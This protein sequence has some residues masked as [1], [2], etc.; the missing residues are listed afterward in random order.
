MS[1]STLDRRP[2]PTGHV[3]T[4]YPAAPVRPRVRRT[5]AGPASRQSTNVATRRPVT[6]GA[7][8]HRIAGTRCA[9]PVSAQRIRT[10]RAG[11]VAVLVGIALALTVWIIGVLGQSYADSV[12]PQPVATEVIHV[13]QGD[14]LST[15]AARVAPDM[16]GETVIKEILRLNDLQSSGLWVGQPL[17]TPEYR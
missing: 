14:S 13:R 15:I 1:T 9:A 10:R 7:V 3:S 16:P 17:L 6:S 8:P 5:S 2:T 11:A 4:L 12:T